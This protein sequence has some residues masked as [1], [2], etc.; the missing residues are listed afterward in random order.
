K[1]NIKE[2]KAELDSVSAQLTFEKQTFPVEAEKVIL[3]HNPDNIK[4]GTV[5]VK[6]AWLSEDWTVFNNVEAKHADNWY[7]SINSSNVKIEPE[8][9]NVSGAEECSTW[10]ESLPENLKTSYLNQIKFTGK[11]SFSVALRPKPTF[12]IKADCKAVCNTVP[13]LRKPFKYTAYTSNR[14][15]FER[16]SGRGSKNWIPSTMMGEM[17]LAATMMEDP[18]FYS[19]R[20]FISQ[21]F[22]NSF[23]DNLKLGRF[24]RGGSTITM[25]LVK[26]IWLTRDK[27]LTRKI[28]EF[29]LA[30]AIESCYSKDEIIELYLNVVE[31]GPNKY[32]VSE[33]SQHWFNRGPAEL[34]PAESFWLASILPRPSKSA[35]PDEKSIERI[36]KLMKKLAEDGKIPEFEPYSKDPEPTEDVQ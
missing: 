17:P 34:L 24:F 4:L 22:A 15:T 3:S 35:P 5:K 8:T 36:E 2:K 32:G 26:N 21:A 16:E 30:Q 10:V 14:E 18:G 19:H 12:N 20:G 11:A 9:L 6:H 28:Q 1:I 27:T 7:L 13:N 25:Q 23:I 33:G 31:F 29:F